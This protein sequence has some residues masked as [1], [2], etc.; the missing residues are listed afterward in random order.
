MRRQDIVDCSL[1]ETCDVLVDHLVGELSVA[2]VGVKTAVA[3]NGFDFRGQYLSIVHGCPRFRSQ[4]VPVVVEPSMVRGLLDAV[5]LKK[6]IESESRTSDLE[7]DIADDEL[8]F[9]RRDYLKY[10]KFFFL[11]ATF[12]AEISAITSRIRLTSD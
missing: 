11:K 9:L 4:Q 7:F 6:K 5:S 8:A 10:G 12:S 3:D 2:D 1:R